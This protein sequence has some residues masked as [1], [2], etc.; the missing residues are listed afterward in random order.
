MKAVRIDFILNAARATRGK[1]H[2]AIILTESSEERVTANPQLSL[3]TW[4]ALTVV[5][6]SGAGAAVRFWQRRGNETWPITEGRIFDAA[7]FNTDDNG[8]GIGPHVRVQYSYRVA[9]EFYSGEIVKA[10]DTEKQAEA[11]AARYQ[12][13]LQVIVRANPAKPELSVMRDDDNAAL[14]EQAAAVSAPHQ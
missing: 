5:L 8:H 3:H 11:F 14:L 7:F 12:R 1:R 13:N 4:F 10:F 6:T 9:G 2:P